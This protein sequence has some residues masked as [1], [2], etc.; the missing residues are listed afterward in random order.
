MIEK[1][2]ITAA[3]G[4]ELLE[5]LKETESVDIPMEV[6]ATTRKK[7][8]YL[9]VRV[10]TEKD[11]T[12]VNIN[13]PLKLVKSLGGIMSNIDA[14][15]PNDAQEKMNEH[16]VRLDQI[17]FEGLIAALEEGGEIGPL[18]DI[19]TDDLENGKTTV[20]IYVE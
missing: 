20:K 6:T 2:Q 4:M 15:I 5:A 17:D 13:V 19:D 1:G 8:E 3:E 11:E 12:K 16:G 14:Y 10:E 9:K 18:V 7:Y